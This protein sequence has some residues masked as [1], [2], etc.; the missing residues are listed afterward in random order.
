MASRRFPLEVPSSQRL[1]PTEENVAH[2][3]PWHC[4][5]D[6]AHAEERL[7]SSAIAPTARA[8]E[9]ETGQWLALHNDLKK[10]HLAM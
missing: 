9:L 2:H 5:K 6:R 1:C 7:S 4:G 10:R 8:E 3:A